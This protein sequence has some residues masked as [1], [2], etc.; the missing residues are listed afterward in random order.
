MQP[1]PRLRDKRLAHVRKPELVRQLGVD[2]GTSGVRLEREPQWSLPIDADAYDRTFAEQ[3]DRDDCPSY[4][5]I[6]PRPRQKDTGNDL[7]YTTSQRLQEKQ[8]PE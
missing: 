8:R 4:T 1:A 3:L 7:L 6:N 5:K 2:H